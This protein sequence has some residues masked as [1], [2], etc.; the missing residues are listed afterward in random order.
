MLSTQPSK[1]AVTVVSRA[2][3]AAAVA[4]ASNVWDSSRYCATAV[5][6]PKAWVRCWAAAPAHSAS[7]ARRTARLV[8][9]S[10]R[11][12]GHRGERRLVFGY[13]L[14]VL[15]LNGQPALPGL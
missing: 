5:G 14:P 2:S 3:S 8:M 13:G 12:L 6:T 11:Q 9:V 15:L 1:W 7:P 4:V 10:S